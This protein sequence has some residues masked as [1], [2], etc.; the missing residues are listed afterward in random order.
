MFDEESAYEKICEAISH[1]E[2]SRC[3]IENLNKILLYMERDF[4][5]NGSNISIVDNVQ[6]EYKRCFDIKYA[7]FYFIAKSLLSIKEKHIIDDVIIN[8][9]L[10]I[11]EKE[12]A[13]VIPK[14]IL[15]LHDVIS[16]YRSIDHIWNMLKY[17]LI[18]KDG[19]DYKIKEY[20]FEKSY[21]YTGAKGTNTKDKGNSI[22]SWLGLPTLNKVH[23]NERL[24]VFYFLA[25][26]ASD[27]LS[28]DI[29]QCII[30]IPSEYIIK[31]SKDIISIYE[32]SSQQD[33]LDS[34]IYRAFS[35]ACFVHDGEEYVART[36]TI[37]ININY[38]IF[39]YIR[40]C[41]YR[42]CDLKESIDKASERYMCSIKN[43]ERVYYKLSDE[44]NEYLKYLLNINADYTFVDTKC[45]NDRINSDYICMIDNITYS[46]IA[47]KEYDKSLEYSTLCNYERYK[48]SSYFSDIVTKYK[49]ILI[50]TKDQYVQDRVKELHKN[51]NKYKKSIAAKLNNEEK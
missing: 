34:R 24:P 19:I 33:D 36:T 41:I 44:S 8:E 47:R 39:K 48:R 31:F 35:Y 29:Y 25:N 51:R 21:N 5:G 18:Y 43:A 15:E 22:R 9:W 17:I 13:R 28:C 23:K 14:K 26:Q 3:D 10:S 1:L 6:D 11:L 50:N 40:E 20:L 49:N 32:A 2:Y 37:D 45:H 38:K 30:N 4:Y 12:V 42:G 7:D 46:Q 16:G 27:Y